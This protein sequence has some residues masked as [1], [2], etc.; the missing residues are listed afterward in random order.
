MIYLFVY[1]AKLVS[2]V[3]GIGQ[4]SQRFILFDRGLFLLLAY[5]E[6]VID[7]FVVVQS[8]LPFERVLF[9]AASRSSLIES[10]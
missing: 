2:I 3:F 10:V 7:T 5:F 4:N 9:G 6:V 1:I 8:S